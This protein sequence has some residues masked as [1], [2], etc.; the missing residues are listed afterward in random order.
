MAVPGRFSYRWVGFEAR[1]QDYEE[2][3]VTGLA[4]LRVIV[5]GKVQGV[6]FRDFVAKQAVELGLS[7]YV[8]NLPDGKRVEIQVEGERPKLEKLVDYLRVGP[9]GSRVDRVAANWQAY[10]GNTK[11]FNVR[12]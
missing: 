1:F 8:R 4:C 3:N 12:Y 11:D 9:P 10:V 7:G 6:F 5:S 2:K